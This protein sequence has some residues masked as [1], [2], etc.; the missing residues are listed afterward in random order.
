LPAQAVV[1]ETLGECDE[2]VPLH[3]SL[4][5]LDVEAVVEQAVEDSLADGGVVIG[6]LG[7]IQGPGAEVV[8]AGAASLILSVGDFHPGDAMVGQGA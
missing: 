2:E 8:A 4:S 1:D 5:L 6:L 3:S 7:D